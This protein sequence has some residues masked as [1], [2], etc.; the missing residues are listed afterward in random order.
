MTAVPVADLAARRQTLQWLTRPYAFLEQC[1]EELGETFAVNFRGHG[2]YLLFSNPEDIDEIF[3][4][5]PATLHAAN[6]LLR[7]FLGPGSLLLLEEDAHRRA[8]RLVMPHFSRR[9]IQRFGEQI[10]DIADEI[11][12][13]WQIDEPF[14]V[15]DAAQDVSL[16]LITRLVFGLSDS[17]R[18]HQL[19]AI[20]DEILGHRHF[21]IALI[22]QF[23]R[24]EAPSETFERFQ[25]RLAEM[26]E[27]IQ[28]EI[29]HRRRSDHR[30][31]DIMSLLLD[32]ELEDGASIS[33]DRLR[34]ELVTLL[35]TGHETTAT[36]LAW[37]AYWVLSTPRVHQRLRAEIDQLGPNPSPD[38]LAEAPY[39]EA[40]CKE[41]LRINPIVPIVAREVQE[42]TTI[43]EHAVEAGVTVAPVIYLVHRRP[44]L[45]PDPDVF[46]P[47][48]FIE[49]SFKHNEYLPFG[50]GRRR[51]LGSHLALYEMKLI[52]GRM[53]A[54][55][56]LELADD[57]P[58][59]PER[60]LVTI[61]PSAGTRIV[62]TKRR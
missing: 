29:E 41:A 53:L 49:R 45:Y 44:E 15:R 33:D 6:D 59:R 28:V 57:S 23:G 4:A 42:A 43:G 32:A 54:Q 13:G 16:E 40:T 11:V 3:R 38:E 46:R 8:R 34:D 9:R 36:A 37:A 56:D 39:L 14:A 10:I 24:D 17:P 50:G 18:Y 48:R 5:D 35:A 27:L 52:L 7:P 1:A 51:C 62:M 21:N 30:G 61:A 47:E 25:A 26:N 55:A 2:D 12:D 60:R 22:S 31:N 19:Q 58:V 20:F